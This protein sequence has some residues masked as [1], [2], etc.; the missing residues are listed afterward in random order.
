M[1]VVIIMKSEGSQLAESVAVFWLRLQ[2]SQQHREAGEL[3]LSVLCLYGSGMRMHLSLHAL[4]VFIH[5]Y[6]N[7]SFLSMCSSHKP[8]TADKAE[9][10]KQSAAVLEDMNS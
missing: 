7:A 10:G 1:A 8:S 9:G 5:M 6:V 4:Y 2:Q 3:I